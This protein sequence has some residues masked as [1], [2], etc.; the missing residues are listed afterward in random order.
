MLVKD[1]ALLYIASTFA[2]TALSSVCACRWKPMLA[3]SLSQLTRVMIQSTRLQ[4]HQ[5]DSPASSLSQLACTLHA[6]CALHQLCVHCFCLLSLLF[7]VDLLLAPDCNQNIHPV[8]FIEQIGEK[9]NNNV[10]TSFLVAMPGHV[11][12]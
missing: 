12:A 11:L 4:Q 5:V 8:F 3:S 10:Y 1:L 7:S 2:T 6:Y 9:C